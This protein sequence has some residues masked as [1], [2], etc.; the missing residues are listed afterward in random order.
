MLR[1]R[2]RSRGDK[3]VME[4]ILGC[5]LL[6]IS[7]ASLLIAYLS[8]NSQRPASPVDSF[9]PSLNWTT[10]WWLS[11]SL[12][13][14]SIPKSTAQ[15]P[16]C[17]FT[18]TQISPSSTFSDAVVTVV[19]GEIYG[20][21]T[22]IRSM[23]TA[24]INAAL[25]VLAD[26]TA[27]QLIQSSIGDLITSCGVI[28]VDV[29]PLTSRQ[30][31][32]RYRTRW[33]L[34]YDYFRLNPHGF[35]R[36]TM[37]DA[38]DSFF[39]GDVFLST[40]SSSKLYFSTESLTVAECRHNSGWI[41]EIAPQA[42]KK[43]NHLPIICAGPVVGGVAPLLELCRIMFAMPEWTSH[44]DKPPDQAYVNVVVRMGYLE[45]AAVAYEVVPNDG[46]ITT[47]GYCD[48]KANLTY[49]ANGNIGCPGFKT[50]PMLLHQYVRPK[51]MRPHLFN[52]CPAGDIPWSFKMDPYS[53]ESF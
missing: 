14:P 43:V 48:R 25:V 24:A 35:K 19:M 11:A 52:A 9:I 21:P 5:L 6:L 15:C 45:K 47:V 1:L 3:F 39:Q 13:A 20:L 38:Y 33:H 12:T 7:L 17:N 4:V 16:L 46:F 34:V 27:A 49:D 28:L 31:K 42:M 8:K 2:R 30:L 37:T 51:N 40:V 29:G 18:P 53:K 32:G 50:I 44:W 10:K 22:T 23:R 36:F 41:H 26:S